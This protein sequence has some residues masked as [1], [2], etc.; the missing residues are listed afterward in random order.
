[1]SWGTE[2]KTD[3][4]LS[5][6]SFTSV[7]EIED[8]LEE[9]DKDIKDIESKIKMYAACTPNNVVCDDDNPISYINFEVGVLLEEYG[10]LLLDRYRLGLYLEYVKEN[11]INNKP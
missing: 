5:R 4:F 11:P 10:D 7:G 9:Y 8:K 1:M 3:I 6:L 2:F